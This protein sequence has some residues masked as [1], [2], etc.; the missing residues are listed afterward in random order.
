[1]VGPPVGKGVFM[2]SRVSVIPNVSIGDNAYLGA[3]TVVLRD[4][5]AGWKMV[6]NPARRIA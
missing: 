3:G 6:G 5:P 1:M 2:A 4:V